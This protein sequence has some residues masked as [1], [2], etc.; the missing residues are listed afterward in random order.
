M[1]RPFQNLE[2]GEQF[3]GPNVQ[4]Q[5]VYGQ[6]IYVYSGLGGYVHTPTCSAWLQDSCVR[7]DVLYQHIHVLEIPH[8]NTAHKF[9]DEDPILG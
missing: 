8:P 1:A 3:R 5:R 4:E 9:G 7:L 2:G 6:E